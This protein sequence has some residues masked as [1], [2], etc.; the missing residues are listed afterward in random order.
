[1]MIGEYSHDDGVDIPQL[2][3]HVYDS[4][5]NFRDDVFIA[6]IGEEDDFVLEDDEIEQN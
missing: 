3:H 6:F 5:D 2:S 1:M 4:V